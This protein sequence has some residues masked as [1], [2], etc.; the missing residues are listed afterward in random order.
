MKQH[1]WADL[2]TLANEDSIIALWRKTMV[3]NA[4][5]SISRAL[6]SVIPVTMVRAWRKLLP[7]VEVDDLQGFPNEEINKSRILDMMCAVRS[8]ENLDEDN[9]EE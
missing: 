2:R 6:S 9:V 8:F 7:D 3:L 4:I 5:Y 1:Y